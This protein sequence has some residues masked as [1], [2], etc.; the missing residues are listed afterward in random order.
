MKPE[1]IISHFGS[2]SE[3]AY[4]LNVTPQTVRNWIK[5]DRVPF[6]WQLVAQFA[7]KGKLSPESVSQRPPRIRK[8][9]VPFTERAV[10]IERLFKD[11]WTMEKIGSEFSITRERVRQVLASRGID[12]RDG[13]QYLSKLRKIRDELDRRNQ[14]CFSKYGCDLE[15]H[16]ELLAMKPRN[17]IIAF[18][19]QRSNARKRGI[20]WDFKLWDWWRVWVESGKWNQRGRGD[21][22]VMA[23]I[24]DSGPYSRENVYITSASQNIR[25]GYVFNPVC[26]RRKPKNRRSPDEMTPRE[27]EIFQKRVS[28]QSYKEIAESIGWKIKSVTA[29]FCRAQKKAKRK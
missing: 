17:P 3:A 19:S 28:G 21:G 22:Y 29:A 18:R 7:S 1:H 13:G 20:K 26:D 8:G 5:A 10:K 25:D 6:Q 12:Y 4:Q 24:K 23:R 11:G 9:N 15:Q 2:M 14:A 16:K 27:I